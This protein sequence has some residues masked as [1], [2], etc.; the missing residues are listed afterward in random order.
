M[1]R[2]P[3]FLRR[4]RSAT[5]S[6]SAALKLPP[7]SRY[8]LGV[9][10][11]VESVAQRGLVIALALVW[12]IPAQAADDEKRE[13]VLHAILINGGK[14]PA[15]NFQSHFHHLEDM[16]AVLIARGI[17]ARNITVFSADGNS[18]TPDMETSS[19][20]P[21]PNYWLVE[22]THVGK[23]L[24]PHRVQVNTT[25]EGVAMRAAKLTTLRT[26]FREASRRIR[27]GDILLIFVTDHGTLNPADDSNNL[28]ALWGEDLSVLELRALL[29]HLKPGVQVAMVMSQCYSGAFANTMYNLGDSHPSGNVCGF[30]STVKER[31][32]YGCYPQGRGR[33][34]F[35]H[36]FRFIDMLG[37]VD[38][39]DDA[40]WRTLVNDSSPDVPIRTSD[41]YLQRL[42][43]QEAAILDATPD[44][45]VD[46]L[47]VEAWAERESW[48]PEIRLLDRIGDAYGTFSP[49]NLAELNAQGGN[50][51]EIS[52]EIKT[53]WQRWKAVY[54]DLR[55]DN[56]KRFIDASPKWKDKLDAKRLAKLKPKAGAKRLAKLLPALRKFTAARADVWKRMDLLRRKAA[57]SS[58]AWQRLELRLAIMLRQ[59]SVLTRIAGMILLAK[60]EPDDPVAKARLVAHKGGL[61]DLMA[62]EATTFGVAP[63]ERVPLAAEEAVAEA[64]RFRPLAEELEEVKSVLPSWLGIRF[65]PVSKNIRTQRGLK[66]GAVSIQV[67][68]PDSP[69]HK[70]GLQ[71]GDIVVGPK[72]A[73]FDEPRRIREWT[74]V[75]PQGVPLPVEVQR[76]EQLIEV[77]LVLGPYPLEWPELPEPVQVGDEAPELTQLIA[78]SDKAAGPLSLGKDPYLLL[79]WATWCGPCKQAVPE[80]LAWSDATGHRVVAIS[81]EPPAMVLEFLNAREAPFVDT[82][83]SDELRQSFVAHSVSGTPTIV[84][85]DAAG[86]VRHRQVGYNVK[87]GLKI[88]GWTW[89]DRPLPKP[90]P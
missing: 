5:I 88:E 44:E 11:T 90:V 24:R 32:A 29:G 75:S 80:L 34:K 76:A 65:R 51:P 40:H 13:P 17:P 43:E 66:R 23:A 7:R 58:R 15:I 78:V 6:L 50:L 26:W 4:H 82:V 54:K 63:E 84:F 31:P 22:G 77:N 3:L 38:T 57:I 45:L 60:Q 27:P 62:C 33:E 61:I 64:K 85:V 72:D 10:Y 48:E 86:R 18:P 46:A 39:L 36:A 9:R 19:G 71:A 73:P 52:G 89:P 42:I 70:A 59:R 25:W 14:Q 83:A 1:T 49:R 53:Y 2:S 87:R 16:H 56:L 41:L 79:F 55:I 47:L 35:G 8:K 37:A 69:A 74:M 12:M 68:F 67:V 30:F 20:N 81:D 28:I 21:P